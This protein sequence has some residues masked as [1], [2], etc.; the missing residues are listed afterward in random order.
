[1]NA[2][3]HNIGLP[4]IPHSSIPIIKLFLDTDVN[5]TI[6]LMLDSLSV[7]ILIKILSIDTC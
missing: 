5:F 7:E 2:L 4:D 6:L 1:M 3:F